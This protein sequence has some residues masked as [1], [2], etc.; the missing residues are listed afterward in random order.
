MINK[1]N[2]N[3]RI[4]I[5]NEKKNFYSSIFKIIPIVGGCVGVWNQRWPKT[6]SS[7]QSTKR[8]GHLCRHMILHRISVFC[9]SK[10]STALFTRRSVSMSSPWAKGASTSSCFRRSWRYVAL[11]WLS[12]VAKLLMSSG[13]AWFSTVTNGKIT[14]VTMKPQEING[15]ERTL[16]LDL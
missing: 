4:I 10:T 16:R 6:A 15:D 12:W 11:A 14:F 3:G 2:S 9:W 7:G 5:R 8:S 13:S 1:F